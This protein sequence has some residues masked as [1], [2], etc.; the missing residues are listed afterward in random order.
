[1]TGNNR[2][3]AGPPGELSVHQRLSSPESST[4]QCQTD[5]PGAGKRE[6][7][8]ARP[9]A[10]PDRQPQVFYEIRTIEAVDRIEIQR[11][12]NFHQP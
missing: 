4:G 11:H 2:E 7:D 6:R 5:D 8:S 3:V 1:M 9:A 10:R 12:R